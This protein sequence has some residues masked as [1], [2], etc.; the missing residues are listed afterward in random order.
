MAE[1]SSVR[2]WRDGGRINDVGG[3]FEKPS[4]GRRRLW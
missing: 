4:V 1:Q 2:L 3:L